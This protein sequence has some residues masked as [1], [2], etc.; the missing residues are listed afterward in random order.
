MFRYGIG[1]DLISWNVE[2]Q[3]TIAYQAGRKEENQ[4]D[5][6][7][8][9]LWH[10]AAEKYLT[11]RNGT[12]LHRSQHGT[13]TERYACFLVPSE[14]ITCNAIRY[15]GALLPGCYNHPLFLDVF[16]GT[17]CGPSKKPAHHSHAESESRE[18]EGE[19]REGCRPSGRSGD[20][21][22]SALEIDEVVDKKRVRA[23]LVQVQ[24]GEIRA[25]GDG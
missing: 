13:E 5:G 8:L 20:G 3:P 25:D 16:F 15:W 1:P 6:P 10:A 19:V 18:A 22:A 2:A 21:V 23:D 24:R 11:E 7:N 9:K 14:K 17:R 4:N 12:M